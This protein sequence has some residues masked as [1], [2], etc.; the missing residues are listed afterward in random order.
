[1]NQNVHSENNTSPLNLL[2][3]ITT[4]R[5][6]KIHNY[7]LSQQLSATIH[8]PHAPI[9]PFTIGLRPRKSTIER[10]QRIVVTI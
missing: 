4:H 3:T 6:K 9:S 10:K 1:M 2:S 8:H 5:Q 7:H